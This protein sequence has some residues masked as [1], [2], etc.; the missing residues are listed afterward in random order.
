MKICLI[1]HCGEYD[2]YY[3][4]KYDENTHEC[5]T[6]C[7]RSWFVYPVDDSY[8]YVCDGK[9]DEQPSCPP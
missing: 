9:E 3:N 5:S 6:E 4:G 1:N 8:V 7:T 2:Y